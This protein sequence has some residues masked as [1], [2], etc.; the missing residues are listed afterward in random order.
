MS[1]RHAR[2][3]PATVIKL[4]A[5]QVLL[6]R[7]DQDD[8]RLHLAVVDNLVQLFSCLVHPLRVRAV[9]DKDQALS[10]CVVMSPERT[11]FVLSPHV[12]RAGG[13]VSAWRV[14]HVSRVARAA[15]GPLMQARK[16]TGASLTQTLNLM[17]L[18]VTVSTLKPTV[19]IVVT[20][21]PSFNRYRIA[22]PRGN[23]QGHRE[24]DGERSVG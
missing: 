18:Y 16:Y 23:G 3:T 9:H 8:C 21:C 5:L 19:G 2:H 17:F 1:L 20:D 7:K 12:L 14:Q 13:R 15:A 24:R 10:P 22:A 11:N 4:T 6:V